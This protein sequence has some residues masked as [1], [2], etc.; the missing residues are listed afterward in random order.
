MGLTIGGA[1]DDL[2]NCIQ[3]TTGEDYD[4][5]HYDIYL[6]DQCFQNYFWNY[7]NNGLKNLELRFYWAPPA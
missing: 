3:G 1:E 5:N 6:F 7:D 4:S 2:Q